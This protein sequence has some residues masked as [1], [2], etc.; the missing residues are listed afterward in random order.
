ME[1]HICGLAKRTVQGVHR[2]S[3]RSAWSG[4]TDEVQ[5]HL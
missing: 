3:P 4:T 1:T 5:G 2:S